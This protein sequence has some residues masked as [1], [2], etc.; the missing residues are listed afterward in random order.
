[1]PR[2]QARRQQ[3]SLGRLA[4]GPD[5]PD[6]MPASTGARPWSLAG[7]MSDETPSCTSSMT[8]LPT[9]NHHHP[10]RLGVGVPPCQCIAPAR[11]SHT[12]VVSCSALLCLFGFNLA[13]CSLRSCCVDLGLVPGPWPHVGSGQQ[14]SEAD[15]HINQC[16]GN[17]I[18]S[19]TYAQ[20]ARMAR[21][22]WAPARLVASPCCRKAT[23]ENAAR[24]S[25]GAGEASRG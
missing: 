11:L 19:H 8:D 15:R 2:P 22:L 6:P 5:G 4:Y 1:M 13:C 16:P 14:G 17:G 9:C 18:V 3:A 12:W 20:D 21:P 23:Q 25:L 24:M 10:A 7:D